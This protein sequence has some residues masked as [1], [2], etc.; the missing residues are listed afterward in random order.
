MEANDGIDGDDHLIKHSSQ[1]PNVEDRHR[2][3]EFKSEQTALERSASG[4]KRILKN[5]DITKRVRDAGVCDYH[6][7]LKTRVR[8][9]S[10]DM[11][12]HY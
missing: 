5:K 4:R 11:T 10:V 6:G 3:F 7:V 12:N 8:I 2:T 9:Y 1:Q